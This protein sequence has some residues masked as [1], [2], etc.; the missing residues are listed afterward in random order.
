VK[1]NERLSIATWGPLDANLDLRTSPCLSGGFACQV[2]PGSGTGEKQTSR[3]TSFPLKPSPQP[4]LRIDSL[5]KPSLSE[6]QSST[7]PLSERPSS[8]AQ[9][10]PR[11]PPAPVVK[12]GA[13][14]FGEIPRALLHPFDIPEIRRHVQRDPRSTESSTG[15]APRSPQPISHRDP[16]STESS[17]NAPGGSAPRS[18]QPKASNSGLCW[19]RALPLGQQQQTQQQCL[20]STAQLSPGAT[21]R[22]VFFIA[23]NGRRYSYGASVGDSV[24]SPSATTFSRTPSSHNVAESGEVGGIPAEGGHDH[25]AGQDGGVQLSGSSP[26]GSVSQWEEYARTSGQQDWAPLTSRQRA[27]GEVTPVVAAAMAAAALRVQ[28]WT[29]VRPASLPTH[30]GVLVEGRERTEGS[31]PG[32]SP[33]LGIYIECGI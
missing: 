33:D 30:K 3:Q 2:P 11:P 25:L 22:D 12:V 7:Q 4:L 16:R 29:T 17:M 5:S 23:G 20:G 18:P 28:E 19:S 10:R 8:A 1:D 26:D 15:L 14:T 6:N 13:A 9:L 24:C 32:S 21:A 31:K 27:T